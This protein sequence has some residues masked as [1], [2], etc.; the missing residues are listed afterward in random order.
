MRKI[1][2]SIIA[3]VTSLLFA[4]SVMA[5][6]PNYSQF[7]LK[8]TYYNPAMT[9][10]NPGLRGTVTD[11]H[12]WTSVPGEWGTQSISFDYYDVKFA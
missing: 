10:I 5:Q 2:I 12:L 8:E 7:Y 11:R 3:A 4:N 9:G 1:Y 6:D